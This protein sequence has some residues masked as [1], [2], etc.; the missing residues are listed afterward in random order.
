MLINRVRTGFRKEEKGKREVSR[1]TTNA[2]R[3]YVSNLFTLDFG[4]WALDS[5]HRPAI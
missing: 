5:G 1:P 4:R 2:Q 3:I